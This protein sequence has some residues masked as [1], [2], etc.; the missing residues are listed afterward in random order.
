[1]CNSGI[2]ALDF[3][4]DIQRNDYGVIEE[5]LMVNNDDVVVPENEIELSNEQFEELQ[6]QN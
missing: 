1:M 2:V 5:G 4:D 3:F 6:Q